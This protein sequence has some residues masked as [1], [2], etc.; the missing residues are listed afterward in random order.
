MDIMA[1]AWLTTHADA[2]QLQ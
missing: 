1:A 2:L